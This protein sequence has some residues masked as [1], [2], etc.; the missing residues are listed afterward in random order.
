MLM[1]INLLFKKPLFDYEQ[2]ACFKIN[3]HDRYV[4]GAGRE[5]PCMALRNEMAGIG[6]ND[7]IQNF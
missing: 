3:T 4:I 2:T 7:D 5:S 6:T 1:F